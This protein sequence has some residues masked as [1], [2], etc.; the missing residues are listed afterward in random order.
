VE[1]LLSEAAVRAEADEETVI[2][3]PLLASLVEESQMEL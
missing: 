1:V 2:Q 3:D